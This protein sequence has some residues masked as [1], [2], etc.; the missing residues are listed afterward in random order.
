LSSRSMRILDVGCGAGNMFHH[1][2]R[3][4]QVTGIENHP[5]PVTAGQARGYDIRQGDGRSLPFPPGEFDLVSAL[6]VIEHNEEDV[7][8]LE[9]MYRVL[10]PGGLVLITVPALQWLWSN[11]DV[12]NAHVRRYTASQIRD[13]FRQAGFVPLRITYNNFFVFPLAA[14]LILSRRSRESEADLHSHYFDEDAYQ[15]DMEPTHPAINALLTAVGWVESQV[16]RWVNLPV[17]TGIV[18][19]GRKE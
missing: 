8:M 1:L 16:L 3:Y 13:L 2:G 10:K 7:K 14:A 9:E 15:V 4:G 18:A 12:L 19:V 11:N 17:G 6:D 5:N